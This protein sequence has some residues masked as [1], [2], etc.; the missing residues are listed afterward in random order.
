MDQVLVKDK[1]EFNIIADRVRHYITSGLGEKKLENIEF[2]IDASELERELDKVWEAKELI[3][4]DGGIDLTGLKDISGVLKKLK[5]EGH[6]VSPMEFLWVL[7]FLRV[8]RKI[9]QYFSSKSR[10]DEDKFRL[11][12][13]LAQPLFSDKILEHNIDIT[14]DETGNVKDSASAELRR[15]RKEINQKEESL[16]KTLSKILKSYSEKEYS[17]EDIV[18]Q[19]DGR[20]V[21]PVKAEN[22][23]SVPGIIHSTSSSGATVFIEPGETID[24]NN[25]IAELGF[26]EKRE[27]EKILREL[28]KQ[29]LDNLDN[30]EINC[31]I[32]G[33]LDFLN[34]KA[35]YAS[36]SMSIK[37]FFNEKVTYLFK[38]YHP[39][40]LINHKKNEIVP[41]D[42]KMGDEFNT[43]IVTGPNAGGKTVALKTV[44]LLQLMFQSG[45][46]V[47]VAERTTMR[48]YDKIF[49]NIGD[50]QS[51]ENDLST[52]SSHLRSLKDIID[53][54]DD[55]S[56]ILIDEICSG[57][58]PNLGSAL[59][60]AILKNFSDR[61]AISIVTT[62]IGQLKNFAYNTPNIENAS[63]EFDHK[64]LSPSFNFVTGLPGQSFTFEIASK[65]D[66]PKDIL[67][68]ANEFADS[69]E[70]KL[71]ELLKEL[72]E[73]KQS[74]NELK[75]KFDR[76]NARLTGLINVYQ[77]K[78]DELEHETKEIIKKSKQEAKHI[79]DE[80]NKLIENTI[81]EI[82]ENKDFSPKEVKEQ[83]RTKSEEISGIQEPEKE[84]VIEGE[85]EV[86]D[87]VR[88]KDT[89][90]TGFVLE[91][92]GNNVQINANGLTLKAKLS[93][94]EKVSRKEVKETNRY[95]E[96]DISM[97]GIKTSLDLRGMYT[98]EVENYIEK[99]LSDA[100]A[101]GMKEVNII[102]GKGSGKLRNEV[103]RILKSNPIV[104]SSR[105][106]GI[107]EGDSG[108]TIVEL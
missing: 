89:N 40:L 54:A 85:I 92:S 10:D 1:L 91:I 99:F 6:Y 65:F 67:K 52:F 98:D 16:R 103:T 50:E 2:Y 97:E 107:R 27:V 35:R 104:K 32:L 77:K 108:V 7:E 105:L 83:F 101:G 57:T 53:N 37:P 43:L 106:G 4:F 81:K 79:L 93:D 45:M 12:P 74:Y 102:H 95:S 39:V 28:S 46:L 33:E 80:A 13:K 26:K 56:L 18:T 8:S 82:R 24:L 23:R 30:L 94:L 70:T 71:E 61:N 75:S 41:L 68:M 63:L 15:I 90:T 5:V 19:R 34:A 78:N 100:Y 17:Q 69:S 9:K 73:N 31:E 88:L 21:I 48:L 60:A 11:L 87:G 42:L 96:R 84:V 44:G 66:Y 36:E 72:A 86:G 38:A 58:D 76:E 22:K 64:T 29:V 20:M 14:I 62:H 49:I 59:S 55:K 47:P 51:I 3:H 25:D